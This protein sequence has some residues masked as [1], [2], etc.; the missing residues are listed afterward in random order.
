MAKVWCDTV[1]E[2]DL[3]DALIPGSD[4]TI[5]YV[6]PIGKGKRLI[7]SHMGA[8]RFCQSAADVFASKKSGAYHESMDAPHF[9]NQIEMA[10]Q[11]GGPNPSLSPT[12]LPTIVVIALETLF[13][14]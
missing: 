12:K 9:G 2:N 7:V 11:N 14:L 8:L 6:I 13:L 4:L 5:R 1:V 3:H 10:F